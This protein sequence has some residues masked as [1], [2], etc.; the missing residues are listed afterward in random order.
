MSEWSNKFDWDQEVNQAHLHVFGFKT[1]RPNQRE[2]I[3]ANLSNRDIFVCMPTGGGKSLTF[4]IPSIIQYGVTLV[5]MTLLS[6]IQD[7]TTFIN[8]LGIKVIFVN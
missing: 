6:L 4:Q 7:K 2:I 5:V 8:G 1:F 3:N